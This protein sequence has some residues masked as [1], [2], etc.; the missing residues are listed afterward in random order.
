[1]CFRKAIKKQVGN[2]SIDPG[3]ENNIG[4][5]GKKQQQQLCQTKH[6]G[7]EI[8]RL[9]QQWVFPGQTIYSVGLAVTRQGKVEVRRCSQPRY[10][11]VG[12]SMWRFMGFKQKETWIWSSMLK[13]N[14][15]RTKIRLSYLECICA[16]AVRAG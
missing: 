13:N 14:F 5:M 7:K 2:V 3:P 6:E 12:F 15:I 1:M 8:N 4:A 16:Q 11:C 9:P 10:M